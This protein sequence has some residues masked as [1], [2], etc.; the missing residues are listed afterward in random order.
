MR[1]V[2]LSFSMPVSLSQYRETVGM[3]I[4]IFA[5]KRCIRP[6]I[7]YRRKMQLC[8]FDLTVILFVLLQAFSVLIVVLKKNAW[9]YILMVQINKKF[10]I[11]WFY[12]FFSCSCLYHEWYFWH[13]YV[14][15]VI[16]KKILRRVSLKRA[17]LATG[18]Q[19]I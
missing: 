13:W 10:L 3:F 18:I 19:I 11:S 5:N 1:K 4:K 14:L 17:L 6:S 9:Q 8:E 16:L 12:W 2:F 7:C 15:V